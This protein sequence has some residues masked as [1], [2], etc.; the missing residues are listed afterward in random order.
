MIP[1]LTAKRDE[2]EVLCRKLGVRRLDVFGSAATGDFK[3][4]TSDLDFLV[5]FEVGARGSGFGG[6]YFN[7][8]ESLEELF[9]RSVDLVMASAIKN[10]YFKE[11]VERSR[12]QLY[13]A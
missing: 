2:I 5:E 1:E 12:V 4:E 7:L 13:A 8:K 6:P 9:G 11:S 10:P 3:P